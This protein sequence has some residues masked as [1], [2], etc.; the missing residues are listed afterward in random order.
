MAEHDGAEH[1]LFGELLGFGFHHQHRV[2]G[3]G[4]DEVELGIDH[5]V[6]RRIEHIL[7]VDLADT[8][9]ADRTHEGNAGN[10]QRRGC[11]DQRDHVGIIFHI[12]AEHLTTT[13]VS[14]R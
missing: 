2:G 12:V 1:D 8:C 14:L 6:D 5:V 3:A 10:R 11:G 7:I 13:C 9:R 4:D